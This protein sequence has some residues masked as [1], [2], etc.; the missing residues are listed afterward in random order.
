[1]PLTSSYVHTERGPGALWLRTSTTIPAPVPAVWDLLVSVG[2]WPCWGPSV[3]A[4]ELDSPR[5]SLGSRGVIHTIAGLRLPF[6]I[7]RF[8]P[9]RAW[10]W[11][12]L[13]LPATDH[14]I[15]TTAEG[16]RVSF[17]VP[18]F[19]APYLAVCAAALRRLERIAVQ[20]VGPS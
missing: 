20:E 19:A 6:E 14:V 8:E 17:G 2:R 1:M 11:S 3:R 16:T 13:G 10:S 18:W 9:Q 15:E 7:T 4:V 5:I 12:V